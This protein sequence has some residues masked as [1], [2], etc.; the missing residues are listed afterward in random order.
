MYNK[1]TGKSCFKDY[2]VLCEEFEQ[3]IMLQIYLKS[4]SHLDSVKQ[5]SAITI[6]R[7]NK[8]TTKSFSE[9][10]GAKFSTNSKS[11]SAGSVQTLSNKTEKS[12][13]LKIRHAFILTLP[14][15]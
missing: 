10:V 8:E 15:F 14:E 3:K 11:N 9:L 1:I 13:D 4:L 5:K 12:E 7:P 2:D 6:M